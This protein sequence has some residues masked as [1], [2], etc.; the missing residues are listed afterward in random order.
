MDRMLQVIQLKR[1]EV[2]TLGDRITGEIEK[3]EEGCAVRRKGLMEELRRVVG[4]V[5]T[6][7]VTEKE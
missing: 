1:G 7:V 5:K 2:E 3:E 6:L 4:E